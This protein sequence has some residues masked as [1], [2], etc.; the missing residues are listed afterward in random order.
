MKTLL[1]LVGITFGVGFSLAYGQTNG[2]IPYTLDS[3][4]INLTYPPGWNLKVKQGR[5][6]VSAEGELKLT[7]SK[8]PPPFFVVS[9]R[10]FS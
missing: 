9:Y 2:W 8:G 4:G 10:I 6:D 1:C 5:F 7:D 3:C